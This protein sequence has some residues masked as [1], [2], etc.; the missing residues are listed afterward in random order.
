[1][2]RRSLSLKHAA[3]LAADRAG[4]ALTEF[5]ITLPVFLLL[6]LGG[7]ELTNLALTH[8]RVSQIAM[9]VADNAG[10]VRSTIDEADVYE[11]FAGADVIGKPL[12]FADR[13]RVV[14][15]SIEDNGQNGARRGQF[16]RWQRCY[17]AM[18]VDP[19]YGVEGDGQADG[20]FKDGLGPDGKRIAAAVD[21]AV[22]FVEATY[23]YEPLI[24]TGLFGT[25]QVR[26]ETAFNVRERN[27]FDITN[28]QSLEQRTCD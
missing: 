24:V 17:G 5:A 6:L 21:T 9:T 11:V 26:Y 13:G 20:T 16:I 8:M 27:S 25:P 1:M 19:A 4:V 2:P 23:D 18:E 12:G 10:R 14:L 3:R 22:M 15:S 28:T 7:L